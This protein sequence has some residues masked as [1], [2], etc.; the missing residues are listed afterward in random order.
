VRLT[1]AVTTWTWWWANPANL[2]TA[3][4]SV[5]G[6]WGFPHRSAPATPCPGETRVAG[7]LCMSAAHRAD[8]SFMAFGS[9]P[10]CGQLWGPC[11][12]AILWGPQKEQSGSAPGVKAEQIA[13]EPGLSTNLSSTPA[14]RVGRTSRPHPPGRRLRPRPCPRD[15]GIVPRARPAHRLVYTHGLITAGWGVVAAPGKRG[16]I[17]RPRDGGRSCD[18]TRAPRAPFRQRGRLNTYNHKVRFPRHNLKL[19]G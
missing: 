19:C 7:D 14:G 4:Q 6:F 10:E 18:P 2:A 16:R 13:A 8:F 5:A 1:R 15:S 12:R 3:G 11:F 17:G 9:G